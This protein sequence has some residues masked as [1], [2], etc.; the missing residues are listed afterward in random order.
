MTPA[1]QWCSPTR[2]SVYRQRSSCRGEHGHQGYQAVVE[3]ETETRSKPA[4]AG[5]HRAERYACAGIARN[6]HRRY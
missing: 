3:N 2:G 5:R 1:G 6:A 4:I